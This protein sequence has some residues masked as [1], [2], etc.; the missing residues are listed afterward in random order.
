MK[1]ETSIL[2]I[3]ATS[4][5][6]SCWGNSLSKRGEFFRYNNTDDYEGGLSIPYHIK[7]DDKTFEQAKKEM[8]NIQ[9][10]RYFESPLVDKLEKLLRKKEEERCYREKYTIPLPR[11]F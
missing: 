3:Q 9:C 11:G 10:D 2:N 8:Y 7:L 1:I 6:I 5:L 4:I